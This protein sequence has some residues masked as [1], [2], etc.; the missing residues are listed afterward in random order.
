MLDVVEHHLKLEKIRCCTIRGNVA[1]KARAELV[2][3]FNTDPKGPEVDYPIN[4]LLY[5]DIYISIR[6]RYTNM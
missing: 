1:P 5:A 2:D 4:R 3:T 6:H